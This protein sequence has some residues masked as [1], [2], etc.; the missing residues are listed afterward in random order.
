[1]ENL[2]RKEEGVAVDQKNID[3]HKKDIYRLAYV[4]DG[5]ERFEVNDTIKEQLRGFVSEV[6][7]NPIDGKNML[8]GQGIP[9]MPMFEFVNLLNTMFGL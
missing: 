8:H 2:H 5:S 3:K 4:F 7:K 6:E 1:M 9:P